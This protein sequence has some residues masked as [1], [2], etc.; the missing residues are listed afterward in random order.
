MVIGDG[1]IH[2]GPTF[3]RDG[4]A[5]QDHVD[6]ADGQGGDE[7]IE[8][9]RHH[10]QPQALPGGEGLQQLH[11]VADIA[12][13]GLGNKGR[14]TMREVPTRRV[15]PDSWPGGCQGHHHR[16]GVVNQPAA[17]NPGQGAVRLRRR[18]DKA[19]EA[20]AKRSSSLGKAAP[21]GMS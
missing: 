17:L 18:H 7:G 8:L 21:M 13:I 16:L 4:E 1:E 5:R 10:L 19:V 15:S 11:V 20:L 9:H 6:L 2:L 14:P 3:I 12:A